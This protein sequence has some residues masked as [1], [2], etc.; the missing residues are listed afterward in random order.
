MRHV[1]RLVALLAG[2]SVGGC[3]QDTPTDL[4]ASR[5]ADLAKIGEADTGGRPLTASLTGAAE[6]PGPGDPDGTGTALITLN[7][8]QNEVC[9]E[10][11]WADGPEGTSY[12]VT[13][14]TGD[15]TERLHQARGLTNP[16]YQVPA[17]ALE[18]I[19]AGDEV[20]W[21]LVAVLPDGTKRSRTFRTRIR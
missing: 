8:G 19:A 3:A 21:H 15:L 2:L 10:L 20:A 16:E 1:T 18:T 9:F 13:V 11:T 6:V 12:D 5:G 14:M 17:A 4:E 7:Q